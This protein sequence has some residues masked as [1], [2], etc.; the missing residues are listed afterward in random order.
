MK[1][2]TKGNDQQV[3]QGPCQSHA[4]KAAMESMYRIEHNRPDDL[5]ALSSAYI[6]YKYWGANLLTLQNYLNQGKTIAQEGSATFPNNCGDESDCNYW[7]AYIDGQ[8]SPAPR[9]QFLNIATYFLNSSPEIWYEAYQ[10]DIGP[11]ASIVFDFTTKPSI[12]Y[13]MGANMT[14]LTDVSEMKNLIYENGPILVRVDGATN[15]GKIKTYVNS[16]SVSFHSFL[17][18]GWDTNSAGQTLWHIKDSW[19]GETGYF[20]SKPNPDFQIMYD[21]GNFQMFQ[22][23]N[24]HRTDVTFNKTRPSYSYSACTAPKIGITSLEIDGNLVLGQYCTLQANQNC[25]IFGQA[26]DWEWWVS[27]TSSRSIVKSG[28]YST[29]LVKPNSA[30]MSMMVKVRVMDINNVWSDWY[31]T[32]LNVEDVN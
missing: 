20:Y 2:F 21:S 31:Q 19:P 29:I 18:I 6:N 7:P 10:S 1:D 30:Q 17:I 28:C 11:S 26:K 8:C 12:G 15:I 22:V 27:N 5:T 3:F 9:H 25:L 13:K 14:R 24:T 23:H 16:T 4:L 32:W